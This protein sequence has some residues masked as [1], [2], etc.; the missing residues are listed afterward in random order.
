[1]KTTQCTFD[2]CMVVL[3]KILLLVRFS[4]PPAEFAT[5]FNIGRD[6]QKIATF[7]QATFFRDKFLKMRSDIFAGD[8]AKFRR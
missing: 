3:M 4:F 8:K 1:M 5:Y 7:W 6:I 2:T